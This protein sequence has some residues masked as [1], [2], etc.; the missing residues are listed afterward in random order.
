MVC[1][2]GVERRVHAVA[3]RRDVGAGPR[4]VATLCDVA[5]ECCGIGAHTERAALGVA[6]DH[7]DPDSRIGLGL[8]QKP[9]V[10]GVHPSRPGI[11][12]LGT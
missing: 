9:P 8:G 6:R 12:T 11:P 5:V 7:H 10:L 3:R 2:V 1:E 4:V